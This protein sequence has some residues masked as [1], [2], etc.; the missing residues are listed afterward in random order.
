MD[1]CVCCVT[2]RVL[3]RAVD[4]AD[5]RL[6]VDAI[7]EQVKEKQGVIERILPEQDA[8]IVRGLFKKE[9]SP[10]VYV[11]LKVRGWARGG[12]GASLRGRPGWL[13]RAGRE[14]WFCACSCW[15]WQVV[16][17]LGEAGVIESA[18][19][20]SGK[21][22]V[23]FAGGLRPGPRAGVANTVYLQCKRY[24]FDQDRKRLRQ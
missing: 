18:F 10:D 12:G 2:C 11:G 7:V 16:T 5:A 20:K 17:G 15:P 14:P 24:I 21:L 8:A 23:A 9:T 22:K 1:V 6:L 19:G 4:R 3:G 13:R